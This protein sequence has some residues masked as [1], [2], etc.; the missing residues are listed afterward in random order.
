MV[1]AGSGG[2]EIRFPLDLRDAV[3][4]QQAVA[5]GET[6]VGQVRL[7][8]RATL[9][10]AAARAP[11]PGRAEERYRGMLTVHLEDGEGRTWDWSYPASGSIIVEGREVVAPAGLV[12]PGASAPS[13][14][15]DALKGRLAVGGADPGS[16]QFALDVSLFDDPRR[17]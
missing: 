3:F 5:T 12:L 16:L 11:S 14:E 10:P 1:S 7:K 8:A 2:K 6:A 15:A 13:P 17:P 4:G 9:A